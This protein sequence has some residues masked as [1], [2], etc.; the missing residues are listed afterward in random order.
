MGSLPIDGKTSRRSHF[1]SG[2]RSPLP[3][4]GSEHD[5]QLS[6]AMSGRAP[7]LVGIYDCLRAWCNPAS[8]SFAPWSKRRLDCHEYYYQEFVKK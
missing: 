8:I 5:L 4:I 7:C 2:S 6:I 3:T 1:G